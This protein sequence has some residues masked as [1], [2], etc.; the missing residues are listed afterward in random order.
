MLWC[1]VI[2]SIKHCTDCLERTQTCSWRSMSFSSLHLQ[3]Y[4][5][6]LLAMIHYF[7]SG[8]MHTQ[9][10]KH[11]YILVKIKM[12]SSILLWNVKQNKQHCH[13]LPSICYIF[14]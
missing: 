8:L 2:L 14:N 6:A 5:N 13:H 10:H 12:I 4:F 11:K 3:E 1:T 7:A 9:E